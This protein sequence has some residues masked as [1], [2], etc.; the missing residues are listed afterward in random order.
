TG[1]R[2]MFMTTGGVL[3]TAA[4]VLILAHYKDQAQGMQVILHGLSFLILL[5]IPPVFLIPDGAR[6]RRGARTVPVHEEPLFLE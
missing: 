1:L 2:G 5:V 6:L 4:I 3:G